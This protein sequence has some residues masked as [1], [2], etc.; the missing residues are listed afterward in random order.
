MLPVRI[1]DH[2]SLNK[3]AL[4]GVELSHIKKLVGGKGDLKNLRVTKV[5]P[6][7]EKVAVRVAGREFTVPV[8]TLV[9]CSC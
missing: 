6:E 1:G 3:K 2:V 5:I 8:S 9:P 7:K 4:R